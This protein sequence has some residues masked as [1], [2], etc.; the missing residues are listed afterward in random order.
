MTNLPTQYSDNRYNGN[1]RGLP[2]QGL[3]PQGLPGSMSNSSYNHNGTPAGFGN[4][5]MGSGL[6]SG[7][8]AGVGLMGRL[9]PS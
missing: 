7:G 2:N 1:S 5:H 3:Y 9:D 6:S 4:Q 8:Y